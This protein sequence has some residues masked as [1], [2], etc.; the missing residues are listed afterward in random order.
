MVSKVLSLGL[1]GIQGY[2][3]GVECFLS[4]G[5]PNFDVVGLPDA[6]IKESRD[7]IRAAIKKCGF[8]FPLRRI[9]VNLAPPDT[10]KVGSIYDLPILLGM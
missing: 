1:F 5:L 4:G 3:V 6:A 7:R 9:T 10:R 2:S 8:D